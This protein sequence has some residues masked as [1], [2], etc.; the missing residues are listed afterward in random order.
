M[1]AVKR[2][3]EEVCL[4]ELL[5]T[6]IGS[7]M[8]K[9]KHQPPPSVYTYAHTHTHRLSLSSSV[10]TSA[11]C[12]LNPA[13]LVKVWGRFSRCSYPITAVLSQMLQARWVSLSAAYGVGSYAIH[14]VLL[15]PRHRRLLEGVGAKHT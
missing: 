6:L 9:N 5:N 12:F 1:V 3:G 7:E 15:D 13:M 2:A 14:T 10:S 4:C 11:M 8:E